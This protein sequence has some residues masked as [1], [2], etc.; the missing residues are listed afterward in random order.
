MKD[1]T[2]GGIDTDKKSMKGGKESKKAA[3]KK[4][5]TAFFTVM[6]EILHGRSAIDRIRM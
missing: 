6:T 2:V 1:E 3:A 4:G 5:N